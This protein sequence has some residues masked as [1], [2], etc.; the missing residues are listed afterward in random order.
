MEN[1]IVPKL[2]DQPFKITKLSI[3]ITPEDLPDDWPDHFTGLGTF[4]IQMW[5][6]ENLELFQQQLQGLKEYIEAMAKA[7]EMYEDLAWDDDESVP[8][9]YRNVNAWRKEG[10]DESWL[11][12]L[13]CAALERD[14]N[15]TD[16][17]KMVLLLDLLENPWPDHLDALLSDIDR[18]L[19]PTNSCSGCEA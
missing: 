5:D 7:V 19:E 15:V 18:F 2:P 14:L 17:C 9:W 10:D 3:S 4:I 1:E 8:E 13:L 11:E 6:E 12:D 16:R